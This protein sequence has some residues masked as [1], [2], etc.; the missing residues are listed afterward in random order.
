MAYGVLASFP[1]KRFAGLRTLW[2]RA[3]DWIMG[4]IDLSSKR[5]RVEL[6]G[7]EMCSF[8]DGKPERCTV[9]FIVSCPDGGRGGGPYSLSR[10]C[11]QET[12]TEL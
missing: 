12:S 11:R 6:A 3:D 9:T 10:T 4:R 2:H 7:I 1:E 8:R 5:F